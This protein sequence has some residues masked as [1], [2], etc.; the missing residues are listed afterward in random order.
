MTTT[1]TILAAKGRRRTITTAAAATTATAAAT[2]TRSIV[3]VVALTRQECG[4][5]F[6]PMAQTTQGQGC[7]QFTHAVIVAFLYFV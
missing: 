5:R 7:I 1:T 6:F 2:T 3:P 4:C